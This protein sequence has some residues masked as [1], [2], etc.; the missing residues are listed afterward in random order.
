VRAARAERRDVIRFPNDRVFLVAV[1]DGNG[2]RDEY[3]VICPTADHAE[4]VARDAA[5]RSAS[6]VLEVRL[7]PSASQRRWHRRRGPVW[8]AV[9][10]MVFAAG[11]VVFAIVLA[12]TL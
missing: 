7:A 8:A 1:A 2:T 9:G 11:T 3:T 12:A 4:S 6:T 10:T 5:S